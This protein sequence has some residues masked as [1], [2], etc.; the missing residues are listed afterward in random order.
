MFSAMKSIFFI[1]LSIN[2]YLKEYEI[3]N[4]KIIGMHCFHQFSQLPEIF[5]ENKLKFFA[6]YRYVDGLLTFRFYWHEKII[7]GKIPKCKLSSLAL[8]G[9]KRLTFMRT[10]FDRV[11]LAISLNSWPTFSSH[12]HSLYWKEGCWNTQDNLYEIFFEA[13][14]IAHKSSSG[15]K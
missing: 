6:R 12:R 5:F 15:K 7:W 4:K 2:I 13:M 11:L 3:N 14:C 8:S 9:A 10:L 1:K